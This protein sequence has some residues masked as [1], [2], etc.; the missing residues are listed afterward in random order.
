MIMGLNEKMT[1]RANWLRKPTDLSPEAQKYWHLHAP[2]LH[3]AGILT[4]N[5]AEEFKILCR[6]LATAR[7]A[8]DE[9]EQHG[10][11]IATALGGRKSNPAVAALMAAQR[12]ALPLL[13]RFSLDLRV[14]L[15]L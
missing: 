9:I 5:T 8:A 7:I 3:D 14:G 2:G 6:L 10:V 13:T 11:T 12:A 15:G 4:V 1:S